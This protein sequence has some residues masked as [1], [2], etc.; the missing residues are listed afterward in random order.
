MGFEG[1]YAVSSFGNVRRV[2]GC[3]QGNGDQNLK[4][5]PNKQGYYAVTLRYKGRRK[6]AAVHR[7]VAEA[8]L[9]PRPPRMEAAHLD[10]VKLN[11]SADNFAWATRRENMQHAIAHGTIRRCDSHPNCKLSS[12]IVREMF[13]MRA[14]G[15]SPWTI[16][17]ALSCREQTVRHIL[18]RRRWK[19]LEIPSEHLV[20]PM[21]T[22][23]RRIAA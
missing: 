22:R 4:R 14:D 10:G 9:S 23:H 19:T 6:E 11:C 5:T 3:P 2:D 20:F 21:L 18:A 13:R 8:F 17:R 15:K 12:A 16:G 7:L 1:I